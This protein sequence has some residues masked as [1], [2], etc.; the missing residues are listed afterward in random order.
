LGSDGPASLCAASAPVPVPDEPPVPPP[1]PALESGVSP[2]CEARTTIVPC[3]FGCGVQMYENVPASLK[4]CEPLS[5]AGRMPVSKLPL[6]AVAE[7][8]LGPLF[9]QV[10]VSP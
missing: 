10:T 4:V 5:P 8:A 2:L 3:M 6:G 9:V 7:C 1:S